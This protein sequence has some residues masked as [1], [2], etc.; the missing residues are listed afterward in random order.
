MCG[1]DVNVNYP[2]L[3]GLGS[4]PRVRSRPRHT[5]RRRILRR[6]HLRVCGADNDASMRVGCCLGSP[7]RV[8]SRPDA[9]QAHA[10]RVGI[11][12]ACAEQTSGRRA[13]RAAS[14]DHL[15]V[16]GADTGRQGTQTR[17]GGSPPRVRSRHRTG[18]D[19]AAATRIT[20]ACAEQTAEVD[21]DVVDVVDHL[22]VCG[23]DTSRR[24]SLNL[25][26][27]SPPRVRSRHGPQPSQPGVEGITS[28]CAEQTRARESPTTRHRDHL[29]VCGADGAGLVRVQD[30][31]GS[32]PRV[33]SRRDD[34][35]HAGRP[36]R[37]TSACAEQT[38]PS[39]Y[40]PNVMRDHLRVCGA[41][42]LAS[43]SARV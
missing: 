14:R 24:G 39:Q 28:A 35:R 21:G 8:R 12:S 26:P 18:F 33:R 30:L 16:C 4:P 29:R 25:V 19:A 17:S 20:S 41:D 36:A 37:I 6:D 3:S 23:A 43:I 22:R 2:Q 11:T 38:H 5:S 13:G 42:S 32:P 40:S 7:P 9:R 10:A 31:P 27:G 34:E 1:A 15:R